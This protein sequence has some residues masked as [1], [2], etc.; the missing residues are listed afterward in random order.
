MKVCVVGID[1]FDYGKHRYHD[2]RAEKLEKKFHPEHSAHV[3][4]EFIPFDQRQVADG[5]IATVDKRLD[6]IVEDLSLTELRISKTDN[7]DEKNVFIKC[8]E[9]LE[10]EVSLDEVEFSDRELQ[11]LNNFHLIT[12]KPIFW[13]AD[14][15]NIPSIDELIQESLYMLEVV[16]FF[17]VNEKE[18][19]PHMVRKGTTVIEAAGKIHSDMER[20]FIRAEVFNCNDLDQFSHMNEARQMGLVKVVDKDYVVQDG[21]VLHIRFHK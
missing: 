1:D 21:D 19:A 5:F 8:K 20:G 6:L 14:K 2:P 18:L 16:F 12:R 15:N 10:K 3:F 4:I 9:F 7:E 17:T 13:I 11:I